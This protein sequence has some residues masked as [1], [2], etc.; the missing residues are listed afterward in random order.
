MSTNEDAPFLSSSPAL[1][2][3]CSAG[4]AIAHFKSPL[5]DIIRAAQA[6]EK[7]AKTQLGRSAVAVTLMKRSGEIIEWGA[8]WRNGLELY[9]AMAEALEAEQISGKFPHRWAELLSAYITETTPLVRE[10]KTVEPVEQFPVD[11]IIGR[12]FDHTISR[13]HGPKFPKE[14]AAIQELKMKL[15]GALANYLQSLDAT[16]KVKPEERLQALIGLCQ[17]V[18]FAHRTRDAGGDAHSAISHPQSAIEPAE[19]QTA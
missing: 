17:T 7:R 1:A 10:A 4:I 6:A 11:E 19:R 13:Q 16:E 8:K 18:G 5:Q 15:R 12:E 3:D 14:Q 9:C 2:A